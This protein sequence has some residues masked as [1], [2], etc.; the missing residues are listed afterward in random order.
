MSSPTRA[1]VPCSHEVKLDEVG[2]EAV[3]VGI[4]DGRAL[5][6]VEPGHQRCRPQ[7]SCRDAVEDE[8]EGRILRGPD[9]PQSVSRRKVAWELP[10]RVGASGVDP[11]GLC[12]EAK[13]NSY[14]FC[15]RR[16]PAKHHHRHGMKYIVAA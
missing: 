14:E 3:L 12:E 10:Q 16:D 13:G 2:D 6:L 9:G 7:G 8:A 11:I 4:D 15:L 1:S 5:H